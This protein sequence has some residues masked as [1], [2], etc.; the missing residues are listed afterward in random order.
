MKIAL[1]IILIF[2]V[3]SI[4]WYFF[5]KLSDIDSF[6][7]PLLD[8][9]YSGEYKCVIKLLDG[10]ANVNEIGFG[11][12]TALILAS[13]GDSK[14]SQEIVEILISNR[15]DVSVQDNSGYT[16][17]HCA[18]IRGRISIVEI[19]LSNKAP[20][21]AVTNDG[22]TPL[23][24][25]VLEGSKEMVELLLMHNA[26]V[27]QADSRG[28]QPLHAVLRTNSFNSNAKER[29]DIVFLLIQYGADVNASNPKG[30]YDTADSTVSP[31]AY[32]QRK[33]MNVNE[34]NTP[35]AIAKS[36]GFEDIAALLKEHGAKE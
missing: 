1:R 28:W 29:K 33:N 11:G 23:F 10:G 20:V 27:N 15:A 26:A 19:L 6:G 9:V 7:N 34:G 14:N 3:I 36:N 22:R 31:F 2:I 32:F 25:S 16:P 5:I 4:L 13:Y 21:N 35:L 18:V 8:A 12:Q 24:L 30:I 17:L